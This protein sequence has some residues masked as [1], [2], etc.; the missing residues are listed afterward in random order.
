MEIRD[1]TAYLGRLD[2]ESP[3][4][5]RELAQQLRDQ[6]VTRLAVEVDERDEQTFTRLGFVP[7]AHILAVDLDVLVRDLERKPR[8]ES[9]GSVHV[10]TD[11]LPT[12]ERIVR[13]FVP[14]LP[15]KSKGTVI[16]P[17]RN[18]WISV[19]D[20]LCDRDPSMLPRLARELS[21]AVGVV[22]ISFA[23]EEGAVARYR[24]YDRGRM[25]DEYLSVP[26]YY[27]PLPPGE[28][29]SLGANPTLV[30]R[31]TGADRR[32]VRSAAVIG[33]SPDELPTPA[34][35]IPS[36]A[37]AMRIEGAD[38]GYPPAR[39]LPDAILIDR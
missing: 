3:E 4:A 5:L 38:H 24:I 23:V 10:Q 37:A 2:N 11:D 28:V 13:R 33:A 25:L 17:P 16:V 35:V 14:T 19:Y 34:E 20:E 27:G 21:D 39:E 32:A 8:G 26:E 12:V 29:V 30:E 9:F 31:L 1:G 22:A 15:G 6:G 7:V 18:G 36:L